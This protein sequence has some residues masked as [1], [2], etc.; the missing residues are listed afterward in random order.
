MKMTKTQIDMS[1]SAASLETWAAK[2]D[3]LVNVA[4]RT[5]PHNSTFSLQASRLSLRKDISK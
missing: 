4:D 1:L 5:F 2:A 3:L